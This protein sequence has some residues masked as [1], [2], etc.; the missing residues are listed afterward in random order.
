MPKENSE[1][2]K[3]PKQWVVNVAYSVVGDQFGAWVREQI[4]ARNLKVAHERDML[5]DLDPEIAAAFAAST[6]VS[7]K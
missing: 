3:L 6:A 5:V 1:L 2:R 7:R 4:E